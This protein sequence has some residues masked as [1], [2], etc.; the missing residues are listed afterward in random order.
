[1]SGHLRKS[2]GGLVA[3]F[4]VLVVAL[5]MALGVVPG[6][7]LAAD[8]LTEPVHNKTISSSPDESGNYT[9]TLDVAGQSIAD[10]DSRPADVVIVL[11]TS[12]SMN[13]R[14]DNNNNATGSQQSRLDYAKDAIETIADGLLIENSDVKISLVS[15]NGSS[16]YSWQLGWHGLE[17]KLNWGATPYDDASVAQEWTSSAQDIQNSLTGVSANGGTNW[18]AGLSKAQTLLSGSMRDADKYVVFISDGN[19]GFYYDDQGYT[20]GDNNPGSGINQDAYVHAVSLANSLGAS[21]LSVGVGPQ[22]NVA[23]LRNFADAVD[24]PY[25]SGASEKDLNSAVNSILKTI[26]RS[27]T[28]RDVSIVDTLSD[29]VALPEGAVDNNGVVS[30]AKISV[31]NAN[32]QDVTDQIPEAM[33]WTLVQQQDG[34]L[35]VDFGENYTLID[36]YTY[37]VSFNVVPTQKAFDETFAKGDQDAGADG[38]QSV[39]LPSNNSAWVNFSIVNTVNGQDDVQPQEPS[40]YSVPTFKVPMSQ[41]HIEKKWTEQTGLPDQVLVDVYQ[42]SSETALITEILNADNGWAADVFVPAG[43]AGHSYTVK[44]NAIAGWH[45]QGISVITNE[46]AAQEV[47]NVDLVGFTAQ[48]AKFTITNAPDTYTLLVNKV[49]EDKEPLC[50][51]EFDLYEAAENGKYDAS[52]TP[53]GHGTITSEIK[54]AEFDGL[55]PGN[56]YYLVETVVPAGYQLAEEPYK[57]YVTEQGKIQFASSE[58][59]ELK[60]AGE[61]DGQVR[62]YQVSFV[63]K[64]FAGSTIPSTGGMGD[65]PLY[66]LGALAIAGSA[67]LVRKVKNN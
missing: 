18:E 48:S 4:A 36:G 6:A 19:A 34:S 37:S 52:S 65:V 7:A 22:D 14:I 41:L 38:F 63:D 30:G 26:N 55:L 64:K 8:E 51:A 53:I 43:P 60:D 66:V 23:Y 46:G 28:Y 5:V 16:D 9:I 67:A 17:W 49:N 21:V 15:F 35:Q 45:Q 20:D 59:G 33:G 58:D 50:G 12:G 29:Y 32:N 10:T 2:L 61:V 47:N 25:Y 40:Y 27:Q 56:T 11:D 57:I 44:E 31:K 24:G 1:M 13:R 42:D 62:T 39:E 54:Q 3:I